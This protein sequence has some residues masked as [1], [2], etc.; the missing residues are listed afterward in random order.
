MG[1]LYFGNV[2]TD[3]EVQILLDKYASASAGTIIPYQEVADTVSLSVDENRFRTVT[4]RWRRWMLNQY[5]LELRTVKN[6]GFEVLT[7][8]A[9]VTANINDGLRLF[10]RVGRTVGRLR[11]IPRVE[12]GTTEA[13][14]LD[15]A[16]TLMA[17]VADNAQQAKLD[18]APPK[19][20]K[21]LAFNR[22]P[23]EVK[24]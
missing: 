18:L 16:T 24:L 6:I 4:Q 22:P 12:L 9:R 10:K 7:A 23:K 5:N 14:R 15:H 8:S 17:K 1:D 19:P 13:Q 20:V 2:S 21:A 11:R 3:H